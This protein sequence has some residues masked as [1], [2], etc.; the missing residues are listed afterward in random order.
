IN[1]DTPEGQTPLA[2]A[3]PI[4]AGFGKDDADSVT[5]ADAVDTVRLFAAT[6]LNGDGVITEATAADD[7]EVR[8]VLGDMLATVGGTPDRSGKQGVDQSRADTFYD[9]CVACVDWLARGRSPEV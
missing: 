9:A 1:P 7:V 5:L 8:Q 6:T 4:L 3:R 2:S